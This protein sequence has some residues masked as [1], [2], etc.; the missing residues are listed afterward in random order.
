MTIK[1]MLPK[2]QESL[3]KFAEEFKENFSGS[4]DY[5]S[6]VND[7]MWGMLNLIVTDKSNLFEQIEKMRLEYMEETI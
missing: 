5:E 2:Q 7:A 6:G 4:S 1:S 3:K